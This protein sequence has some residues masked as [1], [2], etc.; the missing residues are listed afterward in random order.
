[1][2][3]IEE[4]LDESSRSPFADWFDG[5]DARAAAKV[6]AALER[7]ERHL[8]GD[9]QPAVRA[10]PKDELTSDQA[11]E[12]ISDRLGM[13]TE[14]RASFCCVAA[15][16]DARRAISRLPSHTG[17]HTSTVSA[18]ENCNGSDTKL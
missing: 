14:L 6:V 3:E 7:I 4:Y 8:M 18:E 11:I 10:F 17:K 13:N 12:F 5:L 16:R 1:M 2:I 15:R 9:V